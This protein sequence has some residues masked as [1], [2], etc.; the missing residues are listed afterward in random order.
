[1]TRMFTDKLANDGAVTDENGMI[2]LDDL[3]MRE[4][5]QKEVLDIWNSVTS[6]TVKN[7]SDID[8]YWKDFFGLFGFEADGVDYE[9]DVNPVYD[10]ASITE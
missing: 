8:G 4:D 2:R 1:M 7:V 9:A 6:E 3:E 5:V 10:I